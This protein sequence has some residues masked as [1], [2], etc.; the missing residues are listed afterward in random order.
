MRRMVHDPSVEKASVDTSKPAK[1]GRPKTGHTG[2]RSSGCVVARSLM[3]EQVAFSGDTPI[4]PTSEIVALRPGARRV[5]D[6]V[7]L[8][9]RRAHCGAGC[10]SFVGRT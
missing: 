8:R 10:A 6:I 3:R 4:A 2:G 9:R 1:R 5:I 7:R